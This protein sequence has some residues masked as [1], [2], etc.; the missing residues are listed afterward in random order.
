MEGVIRNQKHLGSKP[1]RGKWRRPELGLNRAGGERRL[2]SSDEEY[3]HSDPRARPAIAR[4]VIME[5]DGANRG[6]SG[7]GSGATWSC[8][9][10]D[11]DRLGPFHTNGGNHEDDSGMDA[12]SEGD[13]LGDGRPGDSRGC[14]TA[15]EEDGTDNGTN[16]HSVFYRCV[17]VECVGG[18]KPRGFWRARARAV[19]STGEGSVPGTADFLGLEICSGDAKD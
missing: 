9:G 4:G 13:Y 7:R 3:S 8:A 11:H 16:A 5:S 14:R 12:S 2:G 6:I 10:L 15:G 18:S 19:V 17:S 1:G